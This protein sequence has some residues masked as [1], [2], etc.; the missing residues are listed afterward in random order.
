M[1]GCAAGVRAAL[2]DGPGSRSHKCPDAHWVATVAW[3][4]LHRALTVSLVNRPKDHP[5]EGPSHSTK[6]SFPFLP[7]GRCQFLDPPKGCT[8]L[9]APPA[10]HHLHDRQ[11]S[12][13]WREWLR[14]CC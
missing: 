4:A 3:E 12:K 1:A 9:R 2:G 11:A 7:W 8:A 6:P 10:C 5:P 14:R 13:V